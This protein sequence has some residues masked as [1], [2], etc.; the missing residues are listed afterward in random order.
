[1]ALLQEER[2]EWANKVYKGRI[3]LF[4]ASAGALG[5]DSNGVAGHTFTNEGMVVVVQVHTNDGVANGVY[6]YALDGS[7]VI[8]EGNVSV[9][10]NSGNNASVA[11]TDGLAN[12]T[13]ISSRG[14]WREQNAKPVK[15]FEAGQ[16]FKASSIVTLGSGESTW[17]TYLIFEK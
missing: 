17:V 4:E 12:N 6:L 3:L 9:L 14:D 13:S 1:M 11:M 5:S 8:P 15:W 2:P 10:A 16:V 7:N